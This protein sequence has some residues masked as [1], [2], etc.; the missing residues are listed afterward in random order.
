MVN[1]LQIQ[2]EKIF[3]LFVLYVYIIPILQMSW[4]T[5]F[6]VQIEVL[7]YSILLRTQS[8]HNIDT[9]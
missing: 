6:V 8:H 1:M 4:W 3:A 7:L 2:N 9:Q 5:N